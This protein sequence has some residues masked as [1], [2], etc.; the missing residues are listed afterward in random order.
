[1]IGLAWRALQS[2]GLAASLLRAPTVAAERHRH[3]SLLLSE[4]T[5]FCCTKRVVV[6]CTAWVAVPQSGDVSCLDEYIYIYDSYK[7]V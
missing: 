3:P 1:M 7:S 6:L 4:T 5:I 2:S